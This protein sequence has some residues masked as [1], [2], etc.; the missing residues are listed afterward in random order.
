MS[1]RFRMAAVAGSAV[2]LAVIIVAVA[3][4]EGTKSS[5][6]G[7]VDHSLAEQVAPVVQ[8]ASEPRPDRLPP[9]GPP[10]GRPA[11]AGVGRARTEGGFS[12]ERDGPPPRFG[13]PAGSMQFIT[14]KGAVRRPPGTTSGPPVD[15]R[16]R[17]VAASGRGRYYSDAHVGGTHV[18]VLTVGLGPQGA[19]QAARSRE[20][21]DNVLGDEVLLL[22]LVGTGGIVLAAVL[23]IVVARTALAP[24]TRFTRSTEALS[25]HP[26]T[27]Q[28]LDASGRDEIA[29]L[30]HSFNTTLDAL[31]A[32]VAAQRNL[33]A[34]ASHELRTPIATVR[35]NIQLLREADRLS[36]A[37]Q[38]GLR[39]DIIAELD[40]LTALVSDVV[41]LARGSKPTPAE[42]DVRL[43]E[44]VREVVETARR[45]APDLDFS[46]KVE[47]T[48]VEG[49]PERVARAVSN[50]VDNARRWSPPGGTVEVELVG[51]VLSVR[52]HGPGFH[53][54]DLPHVFDRFYRS[55]RARSEPG[56][57]LGLAIVRQAAEAHGGWARAANAP[58]GGA[59]LRVSFGPSSFELTPSQ[60][61]ASLS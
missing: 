1:L 20:D 42:D 48:L 4:Y 33:V 16:A 30:A 34:D 50:L 31:E 22:I 53:E 39:D 32:S 56:S 59:L 21:V 54:Q 17:A 10:P 15:A 35:A 36:P 60:V 27:S 45:R 5:L 25:A 9:P 46:L 11:G 40:E 3:S 24:I 43:D 23:S 58:N 38:Q 29:R 57:G 52:D 47:S 14:P 2:A 61:S 41:E 6:L 49:E 7:Q 19:V 26:D 44:I 55:E 8:G 12:V 51:S 18:R 37:E 13:E 28:R